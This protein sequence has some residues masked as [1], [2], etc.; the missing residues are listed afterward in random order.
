MN[1]LIF[2]QTTLPV[3]TV[4]QGENAIIISEAQM[5][6]INLT[7]LRYKVAMAKNDQF[8]IKLALLETQLQQTE[9]DIQSLT[10]ENNNLHTQINI[11]NKRIDNLNLKHST[12]I[13]MYQAKQQ[14]K[15]WWFLGGTAVGG[16]LVLV[17]T[18]L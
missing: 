1:G 4:Y 15:I 7:Y 16:L 8:K 10:A 5:D 11:Y 6:S 9:L 13:D 12:E 2:S 14:N 18:L 17:V 3:K